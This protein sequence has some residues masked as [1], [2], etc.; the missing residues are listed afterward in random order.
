[1]MRGVIR[2]NKYTGSDIKWLRKNIERQPMGIVAV[3]K[4]TCELLEL[5]SFW[6]SQWRFLQILWTMA[7]GSQIGL[8]DLYSGLSPLE[9]KLP[10]CL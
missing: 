10:S 8:H 3:G 9:K 2:A 5:G 7:S 4:I 6:G 1:M